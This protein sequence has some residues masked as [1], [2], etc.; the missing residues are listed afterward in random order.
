MRVTERMIFQSDQQ[1]MAVARDQ[2]QKAQA[3]VTTGQRV[4]QPGDDPAAAG[5]IV[6]YS[7]ALQRQ[8]AINQ[9]VSNATGE[10]QAADSSL[11]SVS[12]LLTQASNLAVQLGNDTYSASDRAA[13]AQQISDIKQQVVQLMN[14]QV[15]GRYIFGGNVDQSPPFDATGNYSG[16]TAVRQIEVAP[17]VL[18]A[19]SIRADQTLKG[20]GGGVD[21]FA[22]LD[23]LSTA[24]T[25]NDGPTIRGTIASLSAST[26][27]VASALTQMGGI[28]DSFQS[29]QT[30]GSSAT[31]STQQLLSSQSEADV[32][33]ATSQLTLAQQSLEATLNVA[34]KTMSVSL[35]NYLPTG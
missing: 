26:T 2:V 20:V 28:L 6:S 14:T 16:D 23:A 15:A 19:S 13:G 9:T 3:Q 25:N 12:T 18:Q 35:L 27:Q 17:G 7:V 24:L 34:A 30:I 10:A 21:V 1:Q 8:T 5:L 11:Q 33:D 4:V 29:S 22:S 31:L 32:F